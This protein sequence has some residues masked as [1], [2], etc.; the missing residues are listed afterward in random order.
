MFSLRSE[1]QSVLC[2]ACEH[3]T[4]SLLA[5]VPWH[6]TIGCAWYIE[7]SDCYPVMQVIQLSNVSPVP[8]FTY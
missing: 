7:Q 8:D 4:Q 5:N 3:Q 2:I 6:I 1:G